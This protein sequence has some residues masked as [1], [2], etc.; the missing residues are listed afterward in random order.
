MTPEN[1][2]KIIIRVPPLTP[3]QRK[4]RE[5][6]SQVGTELQI[7]IDSSP[8]LTDYMHAY[9]GMGLYSAGNM[10]WMW[11]DGTEPSVEAALT[12]FLSSRLREQ[13][14]QDAK[15]AE[16]LRPVVEG[17]A[18]R[19]G[20]IKMALKRIRD[21]DGY[22]TYGVLAQFPEGVRAS[23]P[24]L[25]HTPEDLLKVYPDTVF[26]H[27]TTACTSHAADDLFKLQRRDGF[28]VPY[29]TREKAI[30]G[31]QY[32]DSGVNEYQ[33]RKTQNNIVKQ[34]AVNYLLVGVQSAFD[35][36]LRV[37][38]VSRFWARSSRG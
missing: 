6:G 33:L 21:R 17:M 23:S 27:P 8:T 25:G 2:P 13:A 10:D 20:Q 12:Y 19:Q 36:E 5:V 22:Y 9:Y 31:L 35:N 1:R 4:V 26:L 18:D 24:I 37:A 16:D 7:R 14:Q 15:A 3:L 32:D 29:K 11:E 28:Y 30:A 34:D 38:P